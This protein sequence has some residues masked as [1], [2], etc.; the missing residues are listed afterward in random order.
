MLLSVLFLAIRWWLFVDSTA[1]YFGF[2]WAGTIVYRDWPV[3]L[4]LQK[5]YWGRRSS[6]RT[7]GHTTLLF[8]TCSS[9]F[10]I[11]A[12]EQHYCRR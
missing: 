6:C 5:Y 2:A 8:S 1:F 9:L 7:A 10:H 4:K 3:L 12:G 11:L